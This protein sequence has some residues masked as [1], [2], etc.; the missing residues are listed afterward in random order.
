MGVCNLD[1]CL[2]YVLVSSYEDIFYRNKATLK[3][4]LAL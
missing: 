2:T 4:L 1:A 3:F